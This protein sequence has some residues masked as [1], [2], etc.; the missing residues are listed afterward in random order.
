M[1]FAVVMTLRTTFLKLLKPHIAL[2]VMWKLVTTK[3]T[4][5][6]FRLRLFFFK[7]LQAGMEAVA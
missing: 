2:N 3:G 4:G 7:D 6:E 1:N 5:V